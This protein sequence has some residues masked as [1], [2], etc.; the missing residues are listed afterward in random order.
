MHLHLCRYCT[1]RMYNTAFKY[2]GDFRIQYTCTIPYRKV[3][4]N[5]YVWK[6]EV[7]VHNSYTSEWRLYSTTITPY[8]LIFLE[9]W[10]KY[11]KLKHTSSNFTGFS[12][13]LFTVTTYAQLHFSVA[14]GLCS[15]QIVFFSVHKHIKIYFS[16]T[17]AHPLSN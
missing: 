16:H 17:K 15:K 3:Q 8:Y 9:L 11:I 1:Y 13:L 5:M 7:K 6:G 14:I 10:S 12:D 4:N 2:T